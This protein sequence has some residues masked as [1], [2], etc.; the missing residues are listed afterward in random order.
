MFVVMPKM[1]RLKDPL[2]QWAR[3]AFPHVDQEEVAARR[4]HE[5]VVELQ[6]KLW[7]EKSREK[8]LKHGDRYSKFFH[9]SAKL[10]RAKS[11]I[12]E[13]H[14]DAGEVETNRELI[15]QRVVNHFE[16][17]HKKGVSVQYEHLLSVIPTLISSAENDVLVA[18]PSVEEIKQAVMDL[19]PS[20]APGPDGFPGTFFRVCWGIVGPERIPKILATRLAPLLP[21]LISEEQGEFQKGKI[22]FSNIGVASELTNMMK[23]KCFGGSLGLKLDV[24]KAYD[25]LEWQFLFDV[26]RKFGFH[27]RWIKWVH[28]ILVST[29][30]SVLVNG[31]LV[32]FFVWNAGCVKGTRSPRCCSSWRRKYCVGDCK[33]SRK[34][35]ILRASQARGRLA[36]C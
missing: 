4:K 18:V 21:K 19:D 25:T 5:E 35:V 36:R 32:G 30:I 20:S 2:R 23:A 33:G 8:W 27:E 15:G 10:H 28:Q 26:L 12:R 24:Q 11:V 17:F 16:G 14:T 13:L 7:A 29:R 3:S 9:L 1:K 22:I 34:E 6:G 31:G